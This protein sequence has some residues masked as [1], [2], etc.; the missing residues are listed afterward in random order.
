MIHLKTLD[1]KGL[2]EFVSSGDFEKHDFLPITKHR[3]ISQIKNPKA[4]DDQ[5]LLFLAFDD[6]KLAG[7]LGCFPD[8]FKIDGKIFNY[9]WLSTLYVSNE[10]R[11]KRIAQTLLN[12]AFEDY[13][14]NIAITEFTKEAENLYNK[15]GVFEYIQPKIGKR[16]YFRT[17]FK[18]LI[19]SKKTSTKNFK[20]IF[21]VL[22][23]IIN[24]FI[25]VKNSFI[26]KPDFKFE[27]IDTID[28]ESANFISKFHSN[29][30]AG[31]INWLIENPWVLESKKENKN[32]L[33]S[34][35]AEEFKYF[36]IKIYNK[37]NNLITCSLLLL[38]DGH[39][40]VSYLFSNEDLDKFV[41]FL[42]YFIVKNKVKMLTSYQTKLNQKINST[43][44]F[45][46]IYQ[47]NFERRYLF[48]KE[49]I[50]HLPPNFNPD[51]QDG[52]GDCVMT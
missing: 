33:F 14:E 5:T 45:P 49:L 15:T 24:S 2:E 37:N 44:K 36:W 30:N 9:A 31:E 29:R 51:Y 3:A 21:S 17:D 18:T 26:K 7:Y 4:N 8:N 47:K 43:K 50:H 22:D 25:S 6:E 38:R 20:P 28:S 40:K 1:K 19:P 35:F 16:Y 52:D 10:F 34:S 48:H 32:Y 11:G 27:I 41:N 12:K 13:N 39:L 46:K 42:N 23:Q